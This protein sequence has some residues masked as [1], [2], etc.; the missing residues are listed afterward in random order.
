MFSTMEGLQDSAAL[1]PI[2]LTLEVVPE[3][4][5][6]S[7]PALI[8]AVGRDTANA[9]RGEGYTVQPVYTGT[10]GGPFVEIIAFLSQ[11]LTAAWAN[12]EILIADVSGLVSVLTA[13]ATI[14]SKARQ[15]YER[16]VGKD[17]PQQYPISFTLDI[18]GTS[19][20]FS[21]SDAASAEEILQMAQ[22]LQASHPA[23]KG[24]DPSRS[25][26]GVKASIPKQPQHKR[27]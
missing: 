11:A 4:P 7:D 27:R 12:K 21:V 8:D 10:R 22:R 9:L 18:N 26:V 23:L 19:V 3:D 16:R 15:A 1:Q 5:Q 13:A 25:K 14:V 20:P 6:N 17:T 2:K 24:T